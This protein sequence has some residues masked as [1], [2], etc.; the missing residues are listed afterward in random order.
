M[1]SSSSL[2]FLDE[3]CTFA[4]AAGSL[5]G[6]PGDLLLSNSAAL[7]AVSDENVSPLTSDGS[8][9][10]LESASAHYGSN[11]DLATPIDFG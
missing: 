10:S 8:S 3:V 11:G 9:E 1:T 7:L 6:S 2:L 5:L 4:E